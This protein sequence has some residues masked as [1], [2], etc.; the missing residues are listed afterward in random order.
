MVEGDDGDAVDLAVQLSSAAASTS[1]SKT[2]TWVIAICT[3]SS[4]KR[5]AGGVHFLLQ[6]LHEGVVAG[7][8]DEAEAMVAPA[9]KARRE[10]VGAVFQEIDRRL[11]ALGRL[12]VD[13]RAGG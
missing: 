5:S 6:R 13:A 9:R 11:D 10:P 2:S 1:P 12:G 7:R 4:A 3:R 8:Q